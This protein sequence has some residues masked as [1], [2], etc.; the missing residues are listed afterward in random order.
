MASV[1]KINPAY[2]EFAEEIRGICSDFDARGEMIYSG[3]NT[4]KRFELSNDTAVVVKRFGHLNSLRRLIYSTVASSKAQRSY[5]NGMQFLKLGFKT[6]EPVAYINIY[7]SG[8]LSDSYYVALHSDAKSL[9]PVLVDSERF[10]T[11]LA[12][13][14]AQF[15]AELHAAGA[16][17][18]DPNLSN[19]L[20]ERR[21]DGTV[22]LSVIDINRSYFKRHISYRRR[23]KNLMRVTHRRDLMRHIAGRYAELT[24]LDPLATV[25][26]IFALLARFERNRRLRHKLKSIFIR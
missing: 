3:R 12:D 13:R 8:L 20:Y 22:E 19:I 24:G 15:M 11:E 6:P 4:L 2:E 26:R 9:F 21:A 23:M 16:V 18:G 10:S 1:V 14:V 25:D 7:K 5:T 17:H